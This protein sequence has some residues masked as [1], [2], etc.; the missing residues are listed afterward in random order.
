MWAIIAFQRLQLILWKNEKPIARYDR[1]IVSK[2]GPH[3]NKS[4]TKCLKIQRNMCK[5]KST[6]ILCGGR[7]KPVVGHAILVPLI[8]EVFAITARMK[9]KCEEGQSEGHIHK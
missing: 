6:R 8:M 9:I 5:S 3:V 7:G 4:F 1:Q 2:K